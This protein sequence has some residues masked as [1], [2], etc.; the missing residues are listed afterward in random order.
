M[1][2]SLL[3]KFCTVSFIQSDPTLNDPDFKIHVNWKSG[4][5]ITLLVTVLSVLV[6]VMFQ[7]WVL[8]VMI[9]LDLPNALVQHQK[10][11]VS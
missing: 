2:N 9:K 11:P 8:L 6:L 7:I 3:Q 1:I 4:L 10:L 5:A